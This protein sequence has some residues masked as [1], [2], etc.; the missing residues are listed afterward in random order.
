MTGGCMQMTVLMLM[1]AGSD[2]SKLSHKVLLG[3]LPD[4]PPAIIDR[5]RALLLTGGGLLESTTGL[6]AAK[7]ASFCSCPHCKARCALRVSLC[8]AQRCSCHAA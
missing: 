2:T 1:L 6:K 7:H 4:L 8:P 5:V 3:V